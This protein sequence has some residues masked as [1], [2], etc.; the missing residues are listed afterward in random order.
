M[1]NSYHIVSDPTYCY[2]T[3]A[4]LKAWLISETRLYPSEPELKKMKTLSRM[5]D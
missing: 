3:E 1:C 4:S 5:E 2:V